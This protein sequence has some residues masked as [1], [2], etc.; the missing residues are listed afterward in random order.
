MHYGQAPRS[1]RS[2][3]RNEYNAQQQ[4]VEG[5]RNGPVAETP[6]SQGTT[7]VAYEEDY[8]Q[9][10]PKLKIDSNNDPRDP[11]RLQSPHSD[12]ANFETVS[13]HEEE[14]EVR[15]ASPNRNTPLPSSQVFPQAREGVSP[16]PAARPTVI[17][18]DGSLLQLQINF[19]ASLAQPHYSASVY[20]DDEGVNLQSPTAGAARLLFNSSEAAPPQQNLEMSGR[21]NGRRTIKYVEDH[22]AEV[23]DEVQEENV[24]SMIQE[25]ENANGRFAR[26]Y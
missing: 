20:H 11:S 24:E 8:G 7:A 5:G 26:N 6:A 14:A 19:G 16:T 2:P 25:W 22:G 17:V 12:D 4:D 10:P 9:T 18:T 23:S 1:R 3:L 13:L 21:V 15:N